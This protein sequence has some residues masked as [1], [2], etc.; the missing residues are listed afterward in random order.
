MASIFSNGGPAAR[1]ALA[2]LRGRLEAIDADRRI[3]VAVITGRQAMHIVEFEDAECH[4]M[5]VRTI[6]TFVRETHARSVAVAIPGPQ[7]TIHIAYVERHVEVLRVAVVR[8]ANADVM[9][10][11]FAP[12][13]EVDAALCDSIREALLST[14]IGRLEQG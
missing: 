9:L 6:P 1:P 7:D 13:P 3:C 8:T 14:W 4:L 2:L 11:D 5:L 10:G 12:A